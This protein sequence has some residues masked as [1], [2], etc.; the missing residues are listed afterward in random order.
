MT[1]CIILLQQHQSATNS[2][3]QQFGKGSDR[4]IPRTAGGKVT[5]KAENLP[6]QRTLQN[7][8]HVSMVILG[9]DQDHLKENEEK[10]DLNM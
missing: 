6:P 9:K 2:T 10:I 4:S 5:E 8:P 1:I 7:F 3:Q